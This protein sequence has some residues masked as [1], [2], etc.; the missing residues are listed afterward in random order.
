MAAS[1]RHACTEKE[2]GHGQYR[3]SRSEQDT[4]IRGNGAAA[5]RTLQGDQ[6]LPCEPTSPKR[7]QWA[8]VVQLLR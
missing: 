5:D 8:S 3:R 2:E 1:T 6:P 7:D 4:S